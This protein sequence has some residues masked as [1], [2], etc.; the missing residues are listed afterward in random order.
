MS[1]AGDVD[2][3]LIEGMLMS[4]KGNLAMHRCT[5]EKIGLPEMRYFVQ[6]KTD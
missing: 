3:G 2:F 5:K 4:L 1:L 6:V